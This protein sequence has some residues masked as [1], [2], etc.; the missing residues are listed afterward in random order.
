V[1]IHTI[2]LFTGPV[3]W[4]KNRLVIGSDL[5]EGKAWE[6]VFQ[7]FDELLP[8][9]EEKHMNLAVENVWGMLCRDFYTMRY[10]V[11]HYQ[12]PYLGVNYDPSHDLLAGHRDIA[13]IVRCWGGGNI[14]HVHLKDAVGTGQPGQFLFPLPG[15]GDLNWK[16][17]VGALQQVGYSGAM[18]VEF[19]SFAYVSRI[20]KGNWEKA[21]RIAFENLKLL[22]ED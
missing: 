7:A 2:N 4:I 9:A 18:S 1:G 12:S 21:A 17:F 16:E 3:P 20:F 8:L 22:L 11:D 14:K 15:E 6:M 10:L 5:T 13:W 19:E